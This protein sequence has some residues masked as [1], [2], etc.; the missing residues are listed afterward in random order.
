MTARFTWG[1]TASRLSLARRPIGLAGGESLEAA[2][3]DIP[4][5]PAAGGRL[6]G[7]V[8]GSLA[9]VCT[10]A[11]GGDEAATPAVTADVAA[12]T[13]G[14][15]VPVTDAG[16]CTTDDD[17]KASGPCQVATCDKG[18]CTEA[19]REV[20]AA[21]D[22][23]DPCTSGETCTG[24]GSCTSTGAVLACDD[25]DPC[26]GTE[27]C[28]SDGCKPG[29]PL[30]CDDGDPCNGV[31]SCSKG[32]GCVPGEAVACASA[33]FCTLAGAAGDLV[34]CWLSVAASEAEEQRAARLG[35][36]LTWPTG[37]TLDAVVETRCVGGNCFEVVT[38]G[39]TEMA[40]A[41]ARVIGTVSQTGGG[42]S[43][44]V[45]GVAGAINDAYYDQELLQ[46]DARLLA[47]QF[48]L[49]AALSDADVQIGSL[50]G[51]A[52]DTPLTAS[53]IAGIVVTTEA[54]CG[55]A[56]CKD[57]NPCT[58]DVCDADTCNHSAAAGACDDGNPCTGGDT[59]GA[60]GC[61]GT[62]EASGTPCV[63]ENACTEVGACD[64]A[65][66]CT[67]DPK[68]AV[69]CP[70]G[71][72][73]VSAACD[74]KSGS[75]TFA[76]TSG[77]CD[78]GN[79]CTESDTCAAG[80]CTGVAAPCDDGISCTLDACEGTGGCKYT[81]D[82]AAC[83]DGDSCFG[84]SCSAAQGGCLAV[85]SQGTC[86]DGDPCTSGDACA[87]GTCKGAVKPG[88]GCQT[89]ADCVALDDGNACNGVLVCQTGTCALSPESVISC[90]ADG[91]GCTVDWACNPATGTCSGKP[92]PCDDGVACTADSC[93]TTDGC[94]HTADA[95]CSLGTVCELTGAAGGTQD[96]VL[97]LASRSDS[98]ATGANLTFQWDPAILSLE[99]LYDTV[100]FGPTCFEYALADC[101]GSCIW[102]PLEPTQHAVV[103]VPKNPADASG[104]FTALLY[105][106]TASSVPL[107]TATASGTWVTGTP[108]VVT[109][110]FKLLTA[111]AATPVH[112]ADIDFNTHTGAKLSFELAPWTDSPG[113]VFLTEEK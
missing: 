81:P 97:R 6:L 32:Q 47:F 106:P 62:P 105:T 38:P 21:C 19:A 5:A 113:T 27:T 95:S 58:A 12:D 103:A 13:T 2:P 24:E 9:L 75:C 66:A 96:C 85:P 42:A 41:G 87:L 7:H 61:A 22:D 84:W 73:C 45:S 100:C 101:N 16:G 35:F 8:L 14:G 89:D 63:G 64:G 98:P 78:D 46:G 56:V 69:S 76:P 71:G 79:A 34:T 60:G 50:L 20:G 77:T 57:L 80:Q 17:C 68:L 92:D 23:G 52:G 3:G 18:A 86:D 104:K 82:D 30:V 37:A 29:V 102:S 28:A 90:P 31:E 72:P 111:A 36:T 94:L 110:R 53:I 93:S 55:G 54:P 15:D 67:V 26:N 112:V 33:A 109:L 49:T 10:L 83:G 11:C 65:G 88:C 4:K 91:A 59:C 39:A 70:A 40:L 43:V 74:P 48:R 108:D 51:A 107:T 99:N 25:L 1:R 44:E